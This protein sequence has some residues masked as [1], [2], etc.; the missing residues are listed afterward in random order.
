MDMNLFF[1]Q[2]C[3][4]VPWLYFRMKVTVKKCYYDYYCTSTTT[5]CTSISYCWALQPEA[6]PTPSSWQRMID[7]INDNEVHESTL[8]LTKKSVGFIWTIELKISV[9]PAWVSGTALSL[10]LNQWMDDPRFELCQEHKKNWVFPS[11]KCC[12][13]WLS[14]C[15]TPM[16]I[17]TPTHKN[18]H[19]RTLKI[20]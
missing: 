6:V 1:P 7:I 17:H 8:S 15:P 10:C 11:Q 5:T 2:V 12:A 9:W 18:D 20:M 14:M 19:A 4:L 13:D 3:E 16:C